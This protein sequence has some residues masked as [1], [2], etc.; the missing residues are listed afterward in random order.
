MFIID[1][2]LVVSSVILIAELNDKV[3]IYLKNRKY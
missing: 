1:S 2:L 3:T